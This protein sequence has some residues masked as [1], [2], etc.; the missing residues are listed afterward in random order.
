MP[1]DGG[2]RRL[3]SGGRVESIRSIVERRGVK[4]LA[5]F[6]RAENLDGI[7]A[8]GIRPRSKLPS[9][10]IWNDDDRWDGHR[11]ASCLSI[12]WPNYKMFYRLRCEHPEVDWVV[13]AL[14]PSILWECDCAFC[15]TN[16]ASGEMT[17]IPLADR[18]GPAAL[19]RLFQ[20]VGGKPTREEIRLPTRFPTDPQA[21]VLVF[22]TI[23]VGKIFGISV[24]SRRVKSE[25]EGRCSG[26]SVRFDHTPFDGRFDH[27]H[28]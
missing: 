22:D 2:A 21:E 28:W 9:S 24:E 14:D 26:L 25:L 19:E 3:Q 5:H 16:A 11:D 1:R 6:T 20:D 4:L 17:S 18:A 12:S 13:L 15:P 7:L 23:G 10:A 27:Q 8:H